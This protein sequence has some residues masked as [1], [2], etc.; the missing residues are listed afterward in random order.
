[1][2]ALVAIVIALAI[3][4]PL[5]TLAAVQGAAVVADRVVMA[6]ASAR[7]FL[8]RVSSS[9]SCWSTCS[10]SPSAGFRPRVTCRCP[11]GPLPCLNS[12]ILP[13]A[14]ARAC[15]MRRCWRDDAR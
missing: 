2:L 9:R 14:G 8:A 12:L 13:G 4:L 11:R 3:A 5:G 7:L 15:C 6:F 10:R 1:M